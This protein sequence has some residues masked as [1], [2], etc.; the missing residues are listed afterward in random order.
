[1]AMERVDGGAFIAKPEH[2]GQD[3]DL[4]LVKIR[5]DQNIAHEYLMVTRSV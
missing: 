3:E 4:H 2:T 5:V 1:M